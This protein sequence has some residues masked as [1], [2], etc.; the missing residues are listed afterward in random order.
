VAFG[1]LSKQ[2]QARANHGFSDLKATFCANKG[3]CPPKSHDLCFRPPGVQKPTFAQIQA[4]TPQNALL[5]G[6]GTSKATICDPDTGR[7][8]I[9]GHF[10]SG[11]S[12]KQM[13]G[14]TWEVCRYIAFYSQRSDQSQLLRKQR[15]LMCQKPRFALAI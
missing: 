6:S 9:G 14:A 15:L 2:I 7:L 8:K 3:A 13:L 5:C 10:V 11:A 4:P 1:T 12:A